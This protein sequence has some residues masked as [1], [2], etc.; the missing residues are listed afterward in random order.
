LLDTPRREKPHPAREVRIHSARLD[1]PQSVVRRLGLLLSSD[2][3]ERA[4]R[5]RFARDRDRF[6]VGRACLR[7]LL[8]D[9]LERPPE[10]LRFSYDHHRKP[11]LEPPGGLSFNL[12]HCDDFALYAFCLDSGSDVGIDVEPEGEEP[13]EERI[14]EHFF[15]PNEVA[16]LR[17]LP[18]SQ[19]AAA[20]LRC[21]TRKEAF[22]KARGDGLSLPLDAFDV[23]FSPGEQP[24]LLR[25]AWNPEEA[26]DWSLHDVSSPFPGYIAAVAIRGGGWEMRVQPSTVAT[27]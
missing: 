6:L 16:K 18:A 8:G 11:A 1:R 15:S 5:F 13:L 26:A 14:P 22:V 23:A 20:F 2:E 12:A 10:L 24:Q 25:T 7:I 9:Y 27:R 21:W 19:Q 4:E 17:A 3:R